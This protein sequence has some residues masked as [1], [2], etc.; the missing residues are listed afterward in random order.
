M[1]V[2]A[3]RQRTTPVKRFALLTFVLAAWSGGCSDADSPLKPSANGGIVFASKRDGDFDLYVMRADGSD[4][5]NLTNNA[6]RGRNEADDDQPSVSPDGLQ[7]AFLSTRDHE[8]D[9]DEARDV[10]VMDIDGSDVHRVTDNNVAER[11]VDWTPDGGIVF[12]RC[13]SGVYDCSLV[14]VSSDDRGENT[15]F[16]AGDGVSSLSLSPDGN[17]VVFSRWNVNDESFDSNVVVA[18]LNGDNERKLTDAPGI[19]GD[20]DWSPDGTKLVFSSDRD[21]NGDCLFHDCTGYAPEL[22]VM[23]AD[24]SG[25]RRLTEDPAYD[26]FG[27][28]SPDGTKILFARIRG[29]DDD[30]ELFAGDWD[31]GEPKQLTDSPGWDWM[32][33]WAPAG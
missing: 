13:A 12:W 4:V 27:T 14:A 11:N 5:R 22:Y 16:Q 32:P 9:G 28:W 24:G 25:Q 1:G 33:D 2:I 15:L 20:A 30:Y 6:P 19:D 18:D 17:R 7:I 26:V 8:G 31:G 21:H 3:T 29:H 23:N 10:Y